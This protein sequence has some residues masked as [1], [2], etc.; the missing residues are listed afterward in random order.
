[1]ALTYSQGYKRLLNG[2]SI[3]SISSSCPLRD[4]G[5]VACV[6]G[7]GTKKGEEYAVKS[8]FLVNDGC[9]KPNMSQIC[10]KKDRFAETQ[11][12]NLGCSLLRSFFSK[13]SQHQ[14]FHCYCKTRTR[15]SQI[16]C[17]IYCTYPIRWL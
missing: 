4:P 1:M 12:L 3:Q 15:A 9:E 2:Q 5:G 13:A 14:R 6:S 11:A 17:D 16:S 8:S 7:G 10:V